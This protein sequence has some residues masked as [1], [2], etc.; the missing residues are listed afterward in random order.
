MPLMER[1]LDIPGLADALDI[2]ES[3]ARRLVIRGEI[4]GKKVGGK[5]W[6]ISPEAVRD[7]LRSA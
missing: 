5:I 3:H 7:Y 4:K 1:A 6:R 2:S